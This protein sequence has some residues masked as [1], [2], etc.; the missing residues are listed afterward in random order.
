MHKKILFAVALLLAVG[1]A[2]SGC[3]QKKE[4]K[5]SVKRIS[6]EN[7]II[8]IAGLQGTEKLVIEGGKTGIDTGPIIAKYSCS[9]AKDGRDGNYTAAIEGSELS[10]LEQF[11]LSHPSSEGFCTDT[12]GI[13]VS[14]EYFDENII[15]RSYHC[16]DMNAVQGIEDYLKEFSGGVNCFEKSECVADADCV[17]DGCSGEICRVKNSDPVFTTCMWKPEFDCL[18]FSACSCIEGKCA[19]KHNPTYLEC[20]NKIK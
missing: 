8:T 5:I 11:I 9:N 6:I 15:E 2:L 17:A 1:I 13:T 19:W 12:G 4:E 7:G 16:P 20:L 10:E 18:K 14:M 3:T